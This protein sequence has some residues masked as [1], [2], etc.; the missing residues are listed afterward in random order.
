MLAYCSE[1]FEKFV[2]TQKPKIVKRIK[3]DRINEMDF[4]SFLKR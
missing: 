1:Y 2:I 3:N 4:L